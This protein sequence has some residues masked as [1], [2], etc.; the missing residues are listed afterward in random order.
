MLKK[1]FLCNQLMF[2]KL[3]FTNIKLLITVLFERIKLTENELQPYCVQKA[4]WAVSESRSAA[5]LWKSSKHL[6]HTKI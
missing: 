2:T 5:W 1:V 6:K 4:R 3:G